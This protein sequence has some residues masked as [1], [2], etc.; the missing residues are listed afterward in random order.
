MKLQEEEPMAPNR[1][2]LTMLP[3]D[4]QAQAPDPPDIHCSDRAQHV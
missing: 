2:G 1:P 3:R 4:V